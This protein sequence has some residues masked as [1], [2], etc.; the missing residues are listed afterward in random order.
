MNGVAC[1]APKAIAISW[2]TAQW[3]FTEGDCTGATPGKLLRH[4]TARIDIAAR[5]RKSE[6]RATAAGAYLAGGRRCFG[7]FTRAAGGPLSDFK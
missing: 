3:T 5:Q 4:G 1:S 7:R 2:S 6:Q